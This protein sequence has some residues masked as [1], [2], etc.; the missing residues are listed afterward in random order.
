MQ[1]SGDSVR[2][3]CDDRAASHLLARLLVLPD[4][5][6]TSYHHQA[7]VSHPE[8]IR[9][10]LSLLPLIEAVGDDEAALSTLPGVA[11]CARRVDRLRARIDRG[12][13][14]LDVLRP[15]R[16]Q[17][18]SHL[19]RDALAVLTAHRHKHGVSRANIPGRRNVRRRM[20]RV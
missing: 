13:T 9:L 5:P 12:K 14:S 1:R 10:L 8:G 2:R 17:A 7:V 19:P 4:I 11:K 16:H 20:V 6:Q 3:A 15:P 18:P